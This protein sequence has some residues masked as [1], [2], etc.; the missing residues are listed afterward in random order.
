MSTASWAWR[1]QEQDCVPGGMVF[2]KTLAAAA[3]HPGCGRLGLP[4]RQWRV[5]PKLAV[6][7]L[8]RSALAADA[9]DRP[10]RVSFLRWDLGAAAQ[11]CRA[12]RS[13]TA[14]PSTPS[15]FTTN[16]RKVK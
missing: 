3:P 6:C 2:P 13:S 11:A 8:P 4:A 1:T 9:Q 5:A 10:Q 16:M 7:G 12:P 15:G 14:M